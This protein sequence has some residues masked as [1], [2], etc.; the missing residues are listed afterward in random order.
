MARMGGKRTLGHYAKH[1]AFR[2]FGVQMRH[3]FVAVIVGAIAVSSLGL[4]LQARPA[5][6]PGL[7]S[8]QIPAQQ[9]PTIR[10]FAISAEAD[11]VA[12]SEDGVWTAGKEPN[13]LVHLDPRTNRILKRIS[14]PGD[15]CAGLAVSS[16][17]VWVPICNGKRNF[18]IVVAMTTGALVGT[19][20]LGPPEEGGIAAGNG[21]VWFTT[22][23]GSKLTE[24]SQRNLAIRREIAVPKGSYNPIFSDGHVWIT[25][26][27]QDLLTDIAAKTG[28]VIARTRVGPKPRFVTSGEGSIWTLNQGDGSVTRV[29][30]ASHKVLATIPLGIPGAGGD[31]AFGAGTVWATSLGMPLT[32]IE[33]ATNR[34]VKQWVGKGGDS[35]RFGF[36][37][38][39]LTD[40]RRGRLLRIAAERSR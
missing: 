10:D 16:D 3:A 30:Q 13:V 20:P 23:D 8:I 14:L 18:V 11:W 25:S 36:G 21:S 33:A 4:P 26:V 19:I 40:L 34:P 9:L 24:V 35:L 32:A 29:K 28:A 5:E 15:A 38:V 1:M 31:I 12:I 6:K 27:D 2:A 39:W 22:G 7:P 17:R 37:S